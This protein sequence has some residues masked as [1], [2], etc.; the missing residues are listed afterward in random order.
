MAINFILYVQLRPIFSYPLPAFLD[1]EATDMTPNQKSIAHLMPRIVRS[2]N[3]AKALFLLVGLSMLAGCGVVKDKPVVNEQDVYDPQK[4]I[5]Y[6]EPGDRRQSWEMEDGRRTSF[7]ISLPA[8]INKEDE[9][10]P[11]ILA[12]HEGVSRTQ[13]FYGLVLIKGL[14]KPALGDHQAIIVAPDAFRSKVWTNFR[15][16]E[17]VMLLLEKICAEYP[18]DRER[19]M[20]VGYGMGGKGAWHFAGKHPNVFSGAIPV[21]GAPVDNYNEIEW[22][23][24]MLVIHSKADELYLFSQTEAAVN[25]IAQRGGSSQ[26]YPLEEFSHYENQKYIDPLKEAIGWLMNDVWAK[27]PMQPEADKQQ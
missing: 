15:C 26:L 18:V 17:T 8:S 13:P 24:P 27:A 3:L 6:Q 4:F 16:E 11:L 23:V 25:S 2:V 1:L 22:T 21:A 19:I 5:R 20:V 12:L 7:S 14:I 9:K 10:L